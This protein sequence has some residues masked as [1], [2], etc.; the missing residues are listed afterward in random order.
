MKLIEFTRFGTIYH[1]MSAANQPAD[2]KRWNVYLCNYSVIKYRVILN[3]CVYGHKYLLINCVVSLTKN[4]IFKKK[5][6]QNIQMLNIF[7]RS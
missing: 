3:I 1:V 6:F 2:F 5:M 7:N 4:W